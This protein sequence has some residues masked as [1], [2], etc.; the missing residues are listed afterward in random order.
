VIDYSLLPG[1]LLPNQFQKPP[2]A[3]F[4]KR[5]FKQIQMRKMKAF[6]VIAG[7]AGLFVLT[8]A[9]I[10]LQNQETMKE[11][12]SPGNSKGFAVVELFTSEGCSS[13]PPADRLFEKIQQDNQNKQIY[14][15]AF[16]VDYWDHQGWK[17][18]FGDR[19]Y[20]NRQRQY[21][22]WMDLQSIYTPQI[23]VNGKAEYVGSDQG[24]VLPAISNALDQPALSELTL[25]GT[26]EN[27]KAHIGYQ[28]SGK[29]ENTALLLALVQQAAQ[30]SV[31]AGENAG[32][33]LSHV[34]IV[35]QL[36]QI[37]LGSNATKDITI[38]LPKDLTA[39][40]WELVGFV[41]Q[42][43]DGQITAAARLDL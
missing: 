11:L 9:F 15:L 42:Q 6:F 19:Q 27:G 34:Q 3:N 24:S 41:Q 17:D 23:V 10:Q 35:K 28:V 29:Q 43:S 7:L 8:A 22:S 21:A 2:V 30:S 18:R 14:L 1:L 12:K 39:K 32:S 38:D 16:H 4:Y 37:P 31:K 5:Y 26:I 25:T 40:G 20:S 33:Q 13:C 36:R